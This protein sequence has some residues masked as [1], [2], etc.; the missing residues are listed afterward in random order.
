[1]WVVWKITKLGCETY[2]GG[3]SVLWVVSKNTVN[4]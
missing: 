3:E 1:L 2:F 4:N